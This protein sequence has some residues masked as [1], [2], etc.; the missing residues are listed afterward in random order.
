MTFSYLLAD[1][2]LEAAL[3][4]YRA[5]NTSELLPA[6]RGLATVMGGTVTRSESPGG[7]GFVH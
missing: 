1:S 3:G 4:P 2:S 6:R 7:S 5:L